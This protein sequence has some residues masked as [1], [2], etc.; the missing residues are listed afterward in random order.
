MGKRYSR[1]HDAD[2][3]QHKMV[4]DSIEYRVA[5]T[6]WQRKVGNG[7]ITCKLLRGH[8]PSARIVQLLAEYD[9]AGT[10]VSRVVNCTDQLDEQRQVQRL[11]RVILLA[12]TRPTEPGAELA[13][14]T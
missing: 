13:S 5:A 6:L 12:S 8:K 1:R 4:A 10:A 3:T 14:A 2:G 7:S 9:D 11:E